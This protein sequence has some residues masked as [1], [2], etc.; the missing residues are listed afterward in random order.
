MLQPTYGGKAY[1]SSRVFGNHNG[2]WMMEES[3]HNTIQASPLM[4][5]LPTRAKAPRGAQYLRSREST[6]AHYFETHGRKY[7]HIPL[8]LC[9]VLALPAFSQAQAAPHYKFDPDWPK[10]PLPNKWWMMGVTGLG[11]G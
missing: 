11:R 5:A 6:D 2:F 9:G 1:W 4:T 7:S 3:Y 8:A 10:L